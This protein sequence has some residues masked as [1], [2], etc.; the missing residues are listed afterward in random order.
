MA[1][2][3]TMRAVFSFS[4]ASWSALFAAVVVAG[5]GFV[6]VWLVAASESAPIGITSPFSPVSFFESGGGNTF[7]EAFIKAQSLCAGGDY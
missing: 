1:I 3:P 4:W 6:A 5:V 2:L 7:I